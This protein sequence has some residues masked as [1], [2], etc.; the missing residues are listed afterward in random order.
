MNIINPC[1]NASWIKRGS[2][3]QGENENLNFLYKNNNHL[4]YD[5]LNLKPE[6]FHHIQCVPVHHLTLIQDKVL[7]LPL[8]L[9][10]FPLNN[11]FTYTLALHPV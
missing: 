7:Q 10:Y 3:K 5:Y 2:V 1:L 11:G 6:K 9:F 8:H 4:Y